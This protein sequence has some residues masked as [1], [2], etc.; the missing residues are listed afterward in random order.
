MDGSELAR[1][2]LAF[3]T[4]SIDPNLQDIADQLTKQYVPD[5][6]LPAGDVR[7]PDLQRVPQNVLR[8]VAK[9]I[10]TAGL[11]T[12]PTYVSGGVTYYSVS[13]LAMAAYPWVS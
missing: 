3:Q 2:D 11:Q 8:S 9:A 12:M 5:F 6:N 10:W 4:F 1:L 13:G 7:N